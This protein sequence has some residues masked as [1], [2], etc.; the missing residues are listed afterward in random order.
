M[1]VRA[2]ATRH[3]ERSTYII[4]ALSPQVSVGENPLL[5]KAYSCTVASRPAIGDEQG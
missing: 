5:L 2:G 1:L 4:Q 3:T